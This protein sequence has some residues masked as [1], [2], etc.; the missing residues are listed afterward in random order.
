MQHSQMIPSHTTHRHWYRG[1]SII[2]KERLGAPARPPIVR[3]RALPDDNEQN[4]SKNEGDV[5]LQDDLVDALQYEIDKMK[6]K[7]D[8]KKDLEVKKENIRQIGE[9][10]R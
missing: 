7:D 4:P 3:S 1:C 10:V 9:E 6:V 8:I 2:Y 5:K